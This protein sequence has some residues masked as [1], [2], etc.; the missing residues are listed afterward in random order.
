MG[1]I[2]TGFFFIILSAMVS[3]AVY[4]ESVG[5]FTKVEGRVDITRAGSQAEE[6]NSGTLVYEKDIVRSKS[7]SKAEILFTDGN[8]LRLAQNTRVEISEYIN[9]SG[10]RSTVLNLFRGKIQN[11]VKKLLGSVFGNDGNRYEVHTPTAV[12]GVRGT[13]F[14]MYYQKGESGATFK[15]GFGYG[16]NKNA[17]DNMTMVEAGES[18]IIPDADAPPVIQTTSDDEIEQLEGET[19]PAEEE[20]DEEGK[21]EETDIK[22]ESGDDGAGEDN[23]EEAEGENEDNSGTASGSTEETQAGDEG[24]AAGGKTGSTGTTGDIGDVGGFTPE[25]SLMADLGSGGGLPEIP[26]QQPEAVTTEAIPQITP[27]EPIEPPYIPPV[28]P[29]TVEPQVETPPVEP[30]VEPPS[31]SSL[32]AFN[33]NLLGLVSGTHYEGEYVLPRSTDPHRTLNNYREEQARYE[34]QYF[35]KNDGV[36]YIR[37]L[38]E[39]GIMDSGIWTLK[40]YAPD[41]KLFIETGEKDGFSPDITESTWTGSLAFLANPPTGSYYQRFQTSFATTLITGTGSF[42]GD[43]TGVWG[44]LWTATK[45]LPMDITLSG[46]FSSISSDPSYLFRSTLSG[47]F[48]DGGAY[49]GYFGGNAA[50]ASGLIYAL[51]LSPEGTGLGIISGEFS[52]SVDGSGSWSATGK[53]FPIQAVTGRTYSGTEFLSSI[54]HGFL[55]VERLTGVFS[56]SSGAGL[57]AYGFGD[58]S[59]VKGNDWGIFNLAFGYAGYDESKVSSSW[60]GTISGNGLFGEYLDSSQQWRKDGGLWTADI[61]NGAWLTDG[62][63]GDLINGRFLTMTKAGTLGGDL[64]GPGGTAGNWSGISQGTWKKSTDLAF[65]SSLESGL[66]IVRGE[67]GG[68]YSTTSNPSMYDYHYDLYS[69]EGGY[70]LYDAGAGTDT[71]YQ[72]NA[73]SFDGTYADFYSQKWVYN[74]S[75]TNFISYESVGPFTG[76]DLASLA[77]PPGSYGWVSSNTWTSYNMYNTGMLDGIMGGLEN[78]WGATYSNRAGITF[79]GYY[80]AP[81]YVM[82]SQPLIFASKIES[83][84]PYNDTDTTPDGGAYAG[85]IGGVLGPLTK[86]NIFAVYIDPSNRAGILIGDYTGS[87]NRESGIWEAEGGMYPV[88]FITAS[89]SA[90]TLTGS[91]IKKEYSF[92]GHPN[93]STYYYP[94][95]G[96]FLDTMG[97]SS[98]YINAGGGNHS[99]LNIGGE[100][101]GVW[102]AVLGGVY[103][104]TP[105]N[106][107]VISYYR[108][109]Y[110][111]GAG[112]ST[113]MIGKYKVDGTW[114]GNRI[115]GEMLG[116]WVDLS[117]VVP[118]VG[119]SSGKIT[120]TYDPSDSAN[121]KWQ[122]AANGAWVKTGKFLEMAATDSGRATL[123]SLNI[124][125]VEIGRTTLSGSGSTVSVTMNDV[126]FFASSTGGTPEIWA[127]G[128]ITGTFTANPLGQSIYLSSG[129]LNA[130][131]NIKE[132]DMVNNTWGADVFNGYG[133]LNRTDTGTP[134]QIEFSGVAGGTH[135]GGTS[136]SFAGE[137][138]GYVNEKP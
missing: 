138:A 125:A 71:Y 15:E 123:A 117:D 19:T 51:Y 136:G 59:Y 131:F 96:N 87:A 92:W 129:N 2:F 7:N 36:T 89:S 84:N 11:R 73:K 6:V 5:K 114:S 128:N 104:G 31:S 112:S 94:G 83:F 80:D 53:M 95:K 3:Q 113:E 137:G 4:G 69:H 64:T 58:A 93:Y 33:G 35:L 127:A 118:L 79:L 124:P 55:E 40:N 121:M 56:G 28:E 122:S 42:T 67:T 98:G 41:G 81:F 72:V 76:F 60:S 90:G 134:A 52:G 119:V 105:N 61:A 126:T 30:P 50:N 1:K 8:I 38:S 133:T 70:H 103:S 29:S 25:E 97:Y 16:Y 132:W 68:N 74:N 135:T 9:A 49:S 18:M 46:Q 86:G 17:P 57:K 77:S 110:I 108:E 22:N 100:P 13:D 82:S 43:I 111:E 39:N 32:M 109:V 99:S 66:F 12:C 44:E 106:R 91:M 27:V 102:Q 107:W 20:A 65:S 101:W 37:G 54:G 45:T 62:I 88:Q 23:A 116:A 47:T 48:K 21:D 14:F 75:T 130:D 63:S 26:S 24:A 115:E 10:R 78:L 85:F 120:G 34:Y